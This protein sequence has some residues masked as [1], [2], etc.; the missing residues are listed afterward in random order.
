M[1]HALAC[2]FCGITDACALSPAE[3]RVVEHAANLGANSNVPVNLPPF[4]AAAYVDEEMRAVERFAATLGVPWD[5]VRA[6]AREAYERA[7]AE[8]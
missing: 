8:S 1:S 2:V 3:W 4:A 5:R 6:H 7:V